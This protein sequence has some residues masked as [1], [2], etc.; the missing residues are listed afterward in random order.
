MTIRIACINGVNH[1]CVRDIIMAA[2]NKSSQ[3]AGKAWKDLFAK[4]GEEIRAFMDEHRFPGR[5]QR[6]QPVIRMEGAIKMMAWLPSFS[7]LLP[8]ILQQQAEVLPREQEEGYCYAATNPCLPGL[9]KIGFTKKVP[10]RRIKQLSG[11]SVPEPFE[12]IAQVACKDARKTEREIH[13]HFKEQAFKKEFFR[14]P[15]AEVVAHFAQLAI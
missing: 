3:A 6:V 15:E 12:L 10:S 4:H 5:G 11:T 14:V 2:C 8:D 7:L 9:V 1:L 13:R